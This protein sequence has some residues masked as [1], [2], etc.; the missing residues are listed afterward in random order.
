M[1]SAL[2]FNKNWCGTV[3]PAWSLHRI[4]FF[5]LEKKP[6]LHSICLSPKNRETATESRRLKANFHAAIC[7]PDLSATI[8]REANQFVYSASTANVFFHSQNLFVKRFGKQ[9]GR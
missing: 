7:R 8:D 9:N 2:N 3:K 6:L 5:S 4:L 1:V